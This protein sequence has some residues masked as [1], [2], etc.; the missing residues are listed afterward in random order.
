MLQLSMLELKKHIAAV[1][2]YKCKI[3][4]SRYQSK[5][6]LV[7]HVMKIHVGESPEKKEEPEK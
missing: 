3:C 6:D 2:P 1:H 5:K 7:D 4:N